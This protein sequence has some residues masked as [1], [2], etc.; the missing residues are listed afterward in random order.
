MRN[1]R[2]GTALSGTPLLGR[3]PSQEYSSSSQSYF[4]GGGAVSAR[5]TRS[6]R[7]ETRVRVASRPRVA[8]RQPIGLLESV[9]CAWAERDC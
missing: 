3:K 4:G 7:V 6:C 9:E 1:T 2:E 5:P 8:S